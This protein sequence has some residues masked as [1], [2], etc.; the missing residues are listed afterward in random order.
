MKSQ[1]YL[2][3]DMGSGYKEQFLVAKAMKKHIEQRKDEED[4]F[5]C[6]LG[7]N[8][9]PDGCEDMDDKQFI[10][11]FEKPYKHIS[12]DIKFYML[13]GNHDYHTNPKCQIDYSRISKKWHM[14]DEYYTFSKPNVDFFVLNT[15]VE[16]L[17]DEYFKK[18][19]IQMK[20]H[21]NASKAQWK[22]VLGHHT[23]RSIAGHGNAEP[24]LESFLSNLFHDA[25][26]DLYMCGHDHNKQLITTN[27]KGKPIT[28]IVCGSG[29]KVYDDENDLSQLP[30]IK[31]LEF[32]S[33]NLGYGYCEATPTRFTIKFMNEKNKLEYA[34]KMEKVSE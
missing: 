29:G 1:F 28:M 8:M 2:L 19:M 18:Q 6:G 25:P 7:D 32:V 34:Y 17:P 15:N 24:R 10:E 5:V 14:P 20:K 4:I 30:N 31:D 26:F 21:I 16:Y 9:Y 3:G 23:W 27:I 11:K 33:N 12:D 22:V 13:L